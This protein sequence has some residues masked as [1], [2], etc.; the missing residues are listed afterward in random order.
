MIKPRLGL[1]RQWV[2]LA[3][4]A[5]RLSYGFLGPRLCF[6]RATRFLSFIFSVDRCDG[7]ESLPPLWIP[8]EL[9]GMVWSRLSRLGLPQR[10]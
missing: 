8:Y 1:R 10:P 5:L 4:S 6:L 7:R 3:R 9:Y 2:H